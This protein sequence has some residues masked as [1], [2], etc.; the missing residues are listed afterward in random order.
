MKVMFDSNIWQQITI[1]N[2]YPNDKCLSDFKK[3]N[4]AISDKK[5]DGYI[6]EV[7]F[8]IEAIPKRERQEFFSDLK[9][10]CHAIHFDGKPILKKYFDEASKQGLNIVRLPRISGIANPEVDAVRLKLKGNDLS[11]YLDKVFEVGNEIKSHGAGIAHMVKLLGEIGKKYDTDD[12]GEGLKK[13][14]VDEWKKIAKAVAEWADGDLVATSIGLGC[15]YFCTRDQ[16]KGAG[17]G[18]VL[19]SKNLAWLGIK[20]GFK[21]I[22]PEDLAKII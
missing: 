9:R 6:S 14:P 13:A 4:Q 11:Q 7:I 10:Y 16:A 18:S 20:Y 3:I 5:I 15:E 1:P 17:S 2:D 12:W 22:T 19:S 8:T 21:T